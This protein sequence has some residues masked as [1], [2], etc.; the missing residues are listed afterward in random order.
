M[1][2]PKKI[3]QAVEIEAGSAAEEA[4]EYALNELGSLGTQT[5][6]LGKKKTA[7]LHIVGYFE[8]RVSDRL[9]RSKVNEAL[10]IYGLPGSVIKKISWQKIAERDWLAEW[11]KHWRPTETERFIIA[12][13]WEEIGRTEKHVIRI[14]PQMAFGTGTHETTRLCLRLIEREY[15][16]EMSFFDVGCGTGILAIA[17]AKLR[18]DGAGG[19]ADD[20]QMAETAPEDFITGCDTDPEAVRVARENARLNGAGG[21]KFLAGSITDETRSAD[22]VCANV[23]LDIIVPLLPLLI[24]KTRRILVLS[25]ILAEQKDQISAELNKSGITDF[26]LCSDGEWIAL[27]IRLTKASR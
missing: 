20:A 14:E 12:P 7:D 5:D 3:W 25:G 11:K 1:K 22:F 2:E 16:P 27:L 8:E 21:I 24:E 15:R 4:L 18:Q 19:H 23:T 9:L 10:K 17:A 26:E 13:P 6:S